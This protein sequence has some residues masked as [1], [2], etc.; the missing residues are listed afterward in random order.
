[1]DSIVIGIDVGAPSK[2]YH[3]VALR[4]IEVVGKFK[5]A[6]PL[7]VVQWCV[8]QNPAIV[9]IDAPCRWRT[10][11][12]L[13]RASERELAG[14]RIS[15]FS[16]PTEEKARGHAFYSW[17]FAGHALYAALTQDFPIYADQLKGARVSIET[18][19]QAVAYALAGG[20]V[21]A[22]NKRA[23]RSELL[24]RV[25]LPVA[26]LHNMD[27]IDAALCAVAAQAFLAEKFKAYGDAAGGFIIVPS[28][29]VPGFDFDRFRPLAA[30][31]DDEP[32]RSSPLSRIIAGLP[33]LSPAERQTL[34]AR[35]NTLD[36]LPEFR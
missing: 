28:E 5:S 15:C 21:S 1:M 16:T 31:R 3:A 33:Q 23:V 34:R 11:G 35:L 9:S 4:G 36:R 17:M 32:K 10:A 24:A 13:A 7:A 18:F 30:D 14:E 12:A 19:P 25:G 8:Q 22:K 6:E 29:P 27:E 20:I 2:G 26:E